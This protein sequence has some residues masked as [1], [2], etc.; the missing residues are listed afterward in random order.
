MTRAQR[1]VAAFL[2][3]VR[4]V[5]IFALLSLASREIRARLFRRCEITF[6]GKCSPER[7]EKRGGRREVGG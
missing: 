6:G 5:L 2:L 3:A 1:Q 7:W 4:L